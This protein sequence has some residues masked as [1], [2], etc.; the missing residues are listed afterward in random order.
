V[1]AKPGTFGLAR[2]GRCSLAFLS[3]RPGRADIGF[4]YTDLY[5]A[6]DGLDAE[7][8]LQRSG[9]ARGLNRT[10]A[11]ALCRRRRPGRDE[12]HLD[13][14][15]GVGGFLELVARETGATAVGVDFDPAAVESSR[16]H[17]AASGLRFELHAGTLADQPFTDGEFA[18]A[19]MIHFL[20]HS[21]DP[22][23]E[24]AATHRLLADGG[25][26]V[27]EVPSDSALGRRVFGEYWFPYLAPQHIALFSR[28]TLTR[29]LREAGFRDVEVRDVYAP[30]V[31]AASFLLWYQHL[32][33]K[34]SRLAGTVW[35]KIIGL[36]AALTILPI[37]V[38]CDVL[39]APLLPRLGRGDHILATALK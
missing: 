17:G 8:K 13:V 30:F 20:E 11:R 23:A 27:V 1:W 16:K 12:R 22:R 14:G 31:W 26:I 21:Y 24:L 18:T 10:R 36:V 2:C 15:C 4:Y 38:L 39:L 6:E 35:A 5:S 32:C 33:G 25:A 28:A 37:I 3:P 29:A 34:R 9:F 7:E 19:S